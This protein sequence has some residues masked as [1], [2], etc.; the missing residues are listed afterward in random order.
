M[1][2]ATEG[3]PVYGDRRDGPGLLAL[4]YG[5]GAVLCG[6]GALWPMSVRTPVAL[7]AVLAVAGAGLAAGF[8][9]GRDRLPGAAVHGGIALL[10]LLVA[11]VAWQSATAVGV[12]GLGP[13]LVALGVLSGHLLPP[14]AARL[15]VAGGIAAV[16]AGALAAAPAGFASPWAAAVVTALVL[17]EAQVRQTGALRRAAG[18]DALTGVA[19]RRA[20]EEGAERLLAAAGRSGAPLTVAV[21]DLDGFKAVND[22][23]GHAA[24]DALLR[25]L[26]AAWRS[27]LRRSDLLGRVGGD[28]FALCLPGS[29]AAATADLL[30][31][32][33][34]ASAGAWSAGTATARPGETLAEVLARAD[35]A[36]YRQKA[37]RSPDAPA[38][39]PAQGRRQSSE[40]RWEPAIGPIC[41]MPPST[42][43]DAPVT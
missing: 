8:W 20:W 16:S 29:D 10:S 37:A 38:E 36:L 9:L 33:R 34:A 18:T 26:A 32:L 17:T 4:L 19:N 7:L 42:A 11:L 25:A 1:Q 22:T 12:V 13:A 41:S 21:L 31:R 43:Q 15:H 40:V 39:R 5:C 35:A 6:V 14:V 24:G 27:E 30:R 3:V 28:E 23:G 2:S